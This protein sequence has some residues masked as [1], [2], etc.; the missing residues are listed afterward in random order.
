M[1]CAPSDDS[2]QPG[3]PPSLIRVFAVRMKKH[4]VLSYPLIRL[5]RCPCWAE[6]SMG[7]HIILLV[8]SCGRSPVFGRVQL[9]KT[10]T[11]LLSLRSCS[12]AWLCVY[13]NLSNYTTICVFDVFGKWRENWRRKTN[14]GVNKQQEPHSDTPDKTTH[15]SICNPVI[16]TV[17]ERNLMRIFMLISWLVVLRFNVP[18]NNFSVMSG[19]SHRF[20]GN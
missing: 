17:P 16:L 18:V 4:C 19:R 9:G 6:S 3:H 14:N 11:G 8:L 15:L 20:L 2:D 10:Q 13:S 5:G 12:E 1:A 7:A